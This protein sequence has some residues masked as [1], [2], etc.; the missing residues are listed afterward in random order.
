MS[1]IAHL[2]KLM[3]IK[4]HLPMLACCLLMA[5]CGGA[6][7]ALAAPAV[8]VMTNQITQFGITWTFDKPYPTGQFAN[9]DY[10]VVGPVKIVNISPLSIVDGTG[11]T[12]NG[13]MINPSPRNGTTQGYDSAM[14]A[15]FGPDF[16]ASFNVG[17]PN[18]IDLS[19]AN[20]LLVSVNSSLVS[21]IS[22]PTP[23][24]R[25]QLKT[26]AVLTVLATAP[27]AGSFRPPFSGSNKTIRFNKSQLN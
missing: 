20:P 24:A 7:A 6:G 11:R 2:L 18:N 23:G 13:S 8:P 1:N 15:N 16:N 9:G 3:T 5:V 17:R 14:Y 12:M 22:L 19:G 25:P 26:A 21:T 10:W 27:P 4:R